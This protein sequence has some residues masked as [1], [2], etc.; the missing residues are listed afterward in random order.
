MGGK[1]NETEN[2]APQAQ[3][4]PH[5]EAAAGANANPEQSVT[6]PQAEAALDGGGSPEQVPGGKEA[7]A[8]GSQ[9]MKD[10]FSDV[11]ELTAL[12]FFKRAVAQE[13][14][15]QGIRIR[16]EGTEAEPR[17]DD[18]LS[19]MLGRGDAITVVTI[20]GRKFRFKGVPQ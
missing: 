12:E 5:E 19:V 18:L 14:T 20:D 9:E 4:T 3:Q 8:A 17:A 13:L 6:A 1:K 11:P 10:N 2:T 15:A 16:K 7:K